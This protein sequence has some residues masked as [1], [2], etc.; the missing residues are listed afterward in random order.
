MLDP[1]QYELLFLYTS[2]VRPGAGSRS[3]NFIYWLQLWLPPKVSASCGTGSTTL[4][5]SSRLLPTTPIISCV[6]SRCCP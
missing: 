3:R 2:L 6:F 4:E 5:K 1:I